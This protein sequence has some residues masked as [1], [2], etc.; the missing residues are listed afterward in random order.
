VVTSVISY[1][2]VVVADSY[3]SVA[4]EVNVTVALPV[5]PVVSTVYVI[6]PSSVEVV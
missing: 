2:S 3:S 6:L 4:T 1:M 5:L